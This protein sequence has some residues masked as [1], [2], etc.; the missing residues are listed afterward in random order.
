MYKIRYQMGLVLR[1][2][3][4]EAYRLM[5]RQHTAIKAVI[6]EVQ[7]AMGTS[8]LEPLNRSGR[9]QRRLLRRNGL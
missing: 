2:S 1:H 4:L 8:L 3:L 9:S 7:G 6:G 5:G